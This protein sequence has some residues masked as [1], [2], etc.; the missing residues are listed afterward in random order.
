MDINDI[1]EEDRRRRKARAEAEGGY[2]PVTGRGAWGRR[3]QVAT[4]VPGLPLAFVPESM[5][6]DPDYPAARADRAAWQRLR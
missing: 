1:L 4:P 6:A 3:T 5:T 2:D